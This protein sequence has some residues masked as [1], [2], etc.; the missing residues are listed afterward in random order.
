MRID[1]L[2][3]AHTVSQK[4]AHGVSQ[5]GYC[6]IPRSVLQDAKLSA[7]ACR[8]YAFIAGTV[9]HGNT[10]SVGQ[11]RIA[12]M[13]GMSRNRVAASIKELHD[14]QHIEIAVDG[15]KR[16]IFVLKS[17]V[18]GQKQGKADV[19]H[20]GRLVSLDYERHGVKTA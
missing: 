17:P 16:G 4:V 5:T 20:G 8:V 11:R 3:V 10:A 1:S 9:W 12:K 14:L 2:Y 6:R 19:V 15:K 13:L 7:Y 18:F